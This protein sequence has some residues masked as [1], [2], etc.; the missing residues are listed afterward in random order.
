MAGTGGVLTQRRKDAKTQRG[1]IATTNNQHSTFNT[2]HST[3]NIQHST[4]NTQHSTLNI[5]HSTFNTQHSTL[6]I[7]HSTL[8][9]QHSTLNTQH[10]TL[11][12]QHSTLN[13]QHSTLNTQ[14]STLNTQHS[15][16]NTQHSTLNIQHSTFNTQHSTLNIQGSRARTPHPSPAPRLGGER[17][18]FPFGAGVKMHPSFS[19][20]TDYH[21]RNFLFAATGGIHVAKTGEPWFRFATEFHGP[22]APEEAHG[23]GVQRLVRQDEPGKLLRREAI[24]D[25]RHI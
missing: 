3:L 20:T 18:L 25:Q 2:Q 11:N 13:T 21:E 24:F 4:F 23:A 15:T 22:A 6:N 12:T 9:T 17:G 14:H 16:L 19:L 10:S 8:N 5:Q 1:R 7:Q